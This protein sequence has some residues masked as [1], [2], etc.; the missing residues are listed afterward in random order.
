MLLRPSEE[1]LSE[2]LGNELPAHARLPREYSADTRIFVPVVRSLLEPAEPL[3][4]KV[5][6]LGARPIT[7]GCYWRPL[8]T[9]EFQAVPL[10][11]VARGVYR[12]EIPASK[13]AGD[14]EYYVSVT[15]QDGNQKR[16]PATAPQLN[17]SVVVANTKVE[18]D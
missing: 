12:V 15:M 2:V 1:A 6:V 8:G 9:E 13:I 10:S 14:F 17:Q 11:Y 5:I 4:L 3:Q 16:F 18:M 7:A